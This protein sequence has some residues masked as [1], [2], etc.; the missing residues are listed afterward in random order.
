[1]KRSLE[2]SGFRLMLA[3]ALFMSLAALILL[4]E[5]NLHNPT[6]DADSMRLFQRSIGGLGTGASVAPVW[7]LM[8][9]DTRLQSV[10]DS[11]MWPIP[12]SYPYSPAAVS[13]VFSSGELKQEDLEIIRINK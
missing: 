12:G 7:N 6:S 8:H 11:N 9:Y 5:N 3:T 4:S 10:D 2:S 13:T 1:L